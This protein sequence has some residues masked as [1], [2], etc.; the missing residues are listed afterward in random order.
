MRKLLLLSICLIFMVA[1]SK[2]NSLTINSNGLTENYLPNIATSVS[3]SS[4]TGDTIKIYPLSS[5]N[6]FDRSRMN[7]NQGGSLGDLDYIDIERSQTIVGNDT[8]GF[9]FQFDLISSYDPSLSSN[10]RDLLFVS[11][12]DQ[13]NP[14]DTLLHFLFADSLSCTTNNYGFNDTLAIATTNYLNVY[15]N[16]GSAINKHGLYLNATNGLLRFIDKDSVV[17]ELIP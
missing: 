5:S 4:S 15:H 14:S 3:F 10:S 17:Y 6:Y 16:T 7:L 13:T 2:E 1:C 9:K 8:L 11:F 12:E